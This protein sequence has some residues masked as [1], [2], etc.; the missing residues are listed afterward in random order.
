MFRK[1]NNLSFRFIVMASLGAP[2]LLLWICGYYAWDSWRTYNIMN[3]T[4]KANRLADAIIAAAAQEAI[5][6][7]VTAS[8]L[9]A[10]GPVPRAS[11]TQIAELRAKGERHWQEAV[12][13]TEELLSMP[14]VTPVLSKA[15]QEAKLAHD[16]LDEARKRVDASLDKSERDI[17]VPEWIATMTKFIHTAARQRIV[18][19]GGEAFPPRITYPNLTTKHNIWL[20]SEYAGLERA[21]IATVINSEAPVSQD[22]LQRLIS[23]RQII[24]QN[25][26]DI[27]FWKAA[28]GTDPRVAAA[29]DAMEKHFLGDFQKV[30][31]KLYEEMVAPAREGR[32]YHITSGEWIKISTAAINTILDVSASFSDVGEEIALKSAH[33]ALIQA[34]G[35]VGLFFAMMIVSLLTTQLLLGKVRHMNSLKDSMA[36]LADGQGDLTRRLDAE[37]TDEIGQTSAAFN[38]FAEKL[39]QIIRE[40]RGAVFQLSEAAQKLAAASERIRNGSRSQ[41]EM[42]VTTAEATDGVTTSIAQVAE[43]TRETLKSSQEAG[44]LAGEGVRIVRSVADEMTALANGVADTSRQVEALG[45]R[46][47]EIG[48]IVGVIR[49]IAD[50]TNLLALNA[51]IEAARAGEMG[52][53]F[54]VVADEVRKLAERTGAAT[55]DI[56][57]TIDT[58]RNDT[59]AVVEAMRASGARVS[60]GVEMAA[61]AAAALAKINEGA[62]LTES[63][64]EEIARTMREQS[65]A[66]SEISKNIERIAGMAEEN[67][68]VVDETTRDAQRLQQLADG[69]RQVVGKFKV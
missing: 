31:Q 47:R 58:I 10:A 54:A 69:L 45:E 67:D 40:T 61:Q 44:E 11:R 60:Q 6:R 25:I 26:A 8:L 20:A 21:T 66:V 34:V 28:S 13:L 3:V 41:R 14:F 1:L 42:S 63:R 19:F 57:H 68:Q 39:Q 51:A 12:G 56:S 48:G 17:T 62:R 15:F 16:K 49:E 5:E 65:A 37:T 43:H 36:E 9:S 27:H 59:N 22:T 2:A 52:R 55:I 7:G 23:Y 32:R 30:R 35:Y 24:E 64:V 46:S 29:I 38:R 4:V 53:G 33:I 50:Q 18:A